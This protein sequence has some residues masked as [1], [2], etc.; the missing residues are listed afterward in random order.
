MIERWWL[1]ST[2]TRRQCLTVA[3]SSEQRRRWV[4]RS[5]IRRARDQ[6]R[7]P[8]LKSQ[9]FVTSIIA[10]STPLRRKGT[11]NIPR[12]EL[13]NHDSGV[14]AVTRFCQAIWPL[15]ISAIACTTANFW[16]GRDCQSRDEETAQSNRTRRRGVGDE[17]PTARQPSG[18]T[19]PLGRTFVGR[20]DHHGTRGMLSDIGCRRSKEES[21]DRAGRAARRHHE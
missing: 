12:G 2:P 9:G 15:V 7:Q 5:S 13:V 17:T 20:H 1:D 16:R 21:D 3:R 11:G 19:E 10:F 4:Y 18:R 14:S 8:T 6:P